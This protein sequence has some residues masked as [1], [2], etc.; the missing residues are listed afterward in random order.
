MR[1]KYFLI[2]FFC[3]IIIVVPS[4]HAQNWKNLLK[5]LKKEAKKDALQLVR[6]VAETAVD[7][8]QQRIIQWSES[9]DPAELNYAVS[10]SDN[11]GMYEAED[12]FETY[13]R[14]IIGFAVKPGT[15]EDKLEVQV[16][17][18]DE[19]NY[20]RSGQLFYATG[21]YHSAENAFKI[22]L[23]IMQD[24]KRTRTEKYALVESNLG[25]LYQTTG[26][27]NQAQEFSEKA[28]TLRKIFKNP[29]P[30]GASYNNLGVLFKETGNYAEADRCLDKALEL[31]ARAPGKESVAYAIILNNKA[32][33]DQQLGKYERAEQEMV[34]AIS[35]AK[36]QLGNKSPNFV[37]MKVNLAM[38]YQLEGK[39]N[40]AEKIFLEAIALK[41]RRLGTHH[42][43]YAVMLQNLAGLYLENGKYDKVEKPLK[44]ALGIYKKKF[45]LNHPSYA[46]TLA[47]LARYHLWM[48][49]PQKARPE[50]KEAIDV[51]E[52]TL[53][54][55][56]PTL[57]DC[58]ETA[59]ILEWEENN[60]NKAFEDYRKVLDEYILQID[61]YFP[62]LSEYGQA[63][64]WKTIHPRFLR[65]YNLITE[66]GEKIPEASQSLY[67]YQ[68]AT[69]ALLLNTTNHIRKNILNSKDPTLRDLYKQWLDIK[70]YLG[71]VY[72]MTREEIQSEKIN[73][74]SLEN[75]ADKIEK[76]LS[77]KS[78]LFGKGMI[79]S[80]VT[81]RD[82]MKVL[83][84]DEACVEFVRFPVYH[85]LRPD[86]LVR[87]VAM[88]V[89]R[90]HKDPLLVKIDGGN[91]L[92]RK[93]IAKY[94]E[95][96]QQA[97]EKVPYSGVFWGPLDQTLQ[98]KHILYVSP[99]GIYNFINLNTLQ[100]QEG[101]SLLDTYEINYMTN[102]R[103][104]LGL[105]SAQ[106]GF[107]N[108]KAVLAGNPKYDLGFNWDKMKEMP[109]PELPGTETEVKQVRE[110]LSAHQWKVT[111]YLQEG[112]TEE[113]IKT[114]SRP[115]V[116]HLST[117]GYFLPDVPPAEER[118]FGIEP[119]KA[120]AS[121]LLRSGLLFTGADKTIQNLDSLANNGDDG[122]LN[123]YE[124][125]MLDL[126]GTGLV[127]LS[128]CETG[129]GEIQ[130][131]EGVYGLQRSFQLA[132]VSSVM[133]SLWQV[134]DEVTRKLMS[135][136]YTYWLQ[137]GDKQ[138]ALILAQRDV[139]KQYP[140]P[141]YW[142]AFILINK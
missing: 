84:P 9:Y 103:D 131:G 92:E 120:M 54:E 118:I 34:R 70:Q 19:D 27:Y 43:D 26:R 77:G 67:N 132:G 38:L 68:I 37:R 17:E 109:L 140:A 139:K 90:D 72:S 41:K 59:A 128:A 35:I 124:A 46:G 53:P 6:Q 47:D 8:L 141:F 133:I 48:K 82:I 49:Q 57:A 76:E 3:F 78:G 36:D 129:L 136:F 116:L 142:G 75:A 44:E 114:V 23:L 95:T 25:L 21:H 2:V 51:L 91:D 61:R 65:F 1:R 112:A 86:T 113:R 50:I 24:K 134:S 107:G 115:A 33:L 123:A 111:V 121:P 85:F 5:D 127:V 63:S 64:F 99:D 71:K 135:L 94:R 79:N 137:T 30:L 4:G 14:S 100:D 20:N 55:N 81:Y 11:S 22:A 102:T 105:K 110:V 93:Y 7:S 83:A 28:L 119:R 40:Q 62:A 101:N 18:I 31:V 60:Y 29:A 96:M 42:P 106:K 97:L 45:G 108:K 122:I 69:K 15:F 13:K 10:F 32:A 117:H 80:R 87:Y 138:K 52:K 16:K 66:A 39:K 125:S 126:S 73:V 104:V 89:T 12:Q 88:V 58:R 74:D 130:N 98:G 56:H